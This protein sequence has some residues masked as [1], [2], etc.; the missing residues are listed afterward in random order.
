[1]R[2]LTILVLISLGTAR[3]ASVRESALGSAASETA[4]S[5][6]RTANE[7]DSSTRQ[8][9]FRLTLQSVHPTDRLRVDWLDPRGEVAASAPFEELP[10]ASSLCLLSQLPVG[11]FA[12]ASQPGTW[13]V[14]VFLNGAA[15]HERTFRILPDA[16]GG[17]RIAKLSREDLPDHRVR[18]TLDTAGAHSETTVN[19][20]QYTE[21]GGWQY[22]AHLLP[23]AMDGSRITVN[24]PPLPPA[25]YVVILRNPEG[26]QSAP[27]RFLISTDS[28]Y[29]LP[30]V[31][32]LRWVVTQGPYGTYSHWGRT[33][34]AWDL[35]PGSSG[36]REARYV[37]AMRPG[38][39]RAYDLG[40][41]Q[42]PHQ[43]IFGNYITIVHDDGEFSHYAH[44]RTASFLVRTGQRV[45]QGQ[46]L[47]EAGTSGYSFGV[48]LHV[49]VTKSANISSPSI[50][51]RFEDF[52]AGR[53]I[54]YRGP[55][56]S[57]GGRTPPGAGG[58]ADHQTG[59]LTLA[60][61]WTSLL[62]VPSDSRALKVQLGWED[63][64]N[65]FDLYLVSPAGRHY[66]SSGARP[67]VVRIDDP[68]P[69]TWR[70]SVQAVQG[71]G[72]ALPF[73][74]DHE[75]E[76]TRKSPGGPALRSFR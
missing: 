65:D 7:F 70:V 61:W 69:G 74:V 43:R 55:V 41:G 57:S 24:V 8:V 31:P 75:I 19:L 66:S 29:R 30:A 62:S 14:R 18:L 27:A 63:G 40:L 54:S 59:V 49:Q 21:T 36:S 32:G 71:S 23:E 26:V 67:E 3:G 20:A 6:T 68:E 22:L 17:L 15:V 72:T 50:P 53:T 60:E 10:A 58:K 1:M 4:C 13:T 51:F 11:G 56:V 5:L 47:A 37:T 64:S 45:E 16:A 12:P 28:G 39:V 35:A 48:H 73:W 34:H 44:L 76:A 46:P 9:F 33:I 38:I 2:F 42:T 52:P 25:E